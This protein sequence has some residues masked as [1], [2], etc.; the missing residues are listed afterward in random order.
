MIDFIC[1]SMAKEKVWQ[2]VISAIRENPP[3]VAIPKNVGAN[4]INGDEDFYLW[5]SD[6]IAE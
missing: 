4:P 1:K 5:A 2:R 3:L 6:T